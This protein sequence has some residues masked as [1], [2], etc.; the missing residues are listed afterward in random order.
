MGDNHKVGFLTKAKRDTDKKLEPV[1]VNAP[2]YTVDSHDNHK[3]LPNFAPF[4]T[5]SRRELY[6]PTNESPSPGSY[7]LVSNIEKT[8]APVATVFKSSSKRFVPQKS[9][10]APGP[11]YSQNLDSFDD[12]IGTYNLTSYM[13]PDRSMSLMTK[14]KSTPNF[15]TY[16]SLAPRPFQPPS[17]PCKS[18]GWGYEEND[19]GELVP[20]K[21]INPGYSGKRDDSVGPGDYDASAFFK[22][23]S[24]GG[25]FHKGPERLKGPGKADLP[26][27]GYYNVPSAFEDDNM[28]GDYSLKLNPDKKK[29]L[30]S[31]KSGTIREGIVN[32]DM[33]I[34][35]PGKYNIP[36]TIKPKKKTSD[37]QCFDSTQQRF[38]SNVSRSQA[39]Q[40]APGSYTP[41][42]SDFDVNRLKILK[43]KRM[44]SRSGWAQNISFQ[45][46]DER[47]HDFKRGDSPPPGAYTPKTT[48][49]DTLP[50]PNKRSGPF[51]STVKRFFVPK[52]QEMPNITDKSQ[53]DFEAYKN[54]LYGNGERE[55]Q[56]KAPIVE[57]ALRPSR[58]FAGKDDRFK[59]LLDRAPGPPPGHY[60]RRPKLNP[61]G[62]APMV[63]PTS[64]PLIE[65]ATV[66]P[67]P[68]DYDITKKIGEIHHF[69][70]SKEADRF[71]L[72][73]GQLTPGPGY[74][75][76]GGTLV[77]PT[78]NIVLSEPAY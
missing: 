25:L 74:Y 78:H 62:V 39:V 49:V 64:R 59:K 57:K 33:N 58:A 21:P 65:K 66:T 54:S 40:T 56:N 61:T 35:G 14:S 26:G 17:I 50:K 6:S 47:F 76:I 2:L 4:L 16:L 38:R 75:D 41:L 67:G 19:G 28:F 15:A 13:S 73:K 51:G 46:T 44:V 9:D 11:G 68:G 1:T 32:P 27:P 22:S 71:P 37:T 43:H 48:L 24:K 69:K 53:E 20:Q 70:P 52:S 60:Y 77:L 42:V 5:S 12:D 18:Q 34:P 72:K 63:E 55:Q 7:N 10:V 29:Q 3:S 30:S 45:S 36:S 31:F 23:K 8:R